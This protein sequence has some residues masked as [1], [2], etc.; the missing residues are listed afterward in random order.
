MNHEPN[1][2]DDLL[3]LLYQSLDTGLVIQQDIYS[4]FQTKYRDAPDLFVLECIHWNEKRDEHPTAYQLEMLR[5][6]AL[7]HRIS[8][9]GPHGLGKTAF[10]AWVVLWFSLTRDGEDWKIPTTASAWRQV[11]K[12][13]WPEIRKW[14]RRL[15]WNLV[16][17][18]PFREPYELQ[19][20]G[21]KLQ[22][23]EAFAVVSDNHELIEGAHADQLLYIFDEAKA[24]PEE[25]FD[26]AE[27]AFSGSGTDTFVDAYALAI[28]TPGEPQGRFYDIHKRKPGYEDWDVRHVTLEEAIE[29]GRISREWA[30][31]RAL[32]WGES[33]AVYQNRVMGEF[34][35]SAED[36]VI[37]LAWIE[38]ANQRYE[39]V[40]L[41]LNHA[42]FRG[43]GV[44]VGRGGDMSVLAPRFDNHIVELRRNPAADTMVIAGEVVK[45]LRGFPHG[46]AVVDVVG[47]GAG[48][49]DRLREMGHGD[50][51]I[52]FN[53]GG[54]TD[55]V[56]GSGELMFVDCRSAAWW[57]MRE[58]LNPTNGHEVGLPPDDKLIG[59]LTAPKWS[60]TSGGKIKV[61]AKDQI[62][63]RLGRS[64][65]DGDAVIQAFWADQQVIEL[66][67]QQMAPQPFRFSSSPY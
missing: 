41:D 1:P 61:E 49:V 12:F 44:D 5:R 7:R 65:D 40:V 32:Q 4:T 15:K 52:A 55:Y 42:V 34:A 60:L 48:V 14:S 58:M 8:M 19:T 53:A 11:T 43:V 36:G 66:S 21:L 33:S 24:I 27:G 37:P 56:D 9:R 13:L 62:K 10:A 25:T 6:L 18:E 57:H 46:H 38:L 17:R 22:T 16:G 31:Q 2:A 63:R 50:R 29:A 45:L 47:I 59:D 28:S 67:G 51:V 35:S 54:H 3:E 23:G 64:T 20:L 26:A 39:D 30:N